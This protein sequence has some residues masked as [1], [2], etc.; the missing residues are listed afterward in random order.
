ML[1]TMVGALLLAR[2]VND[3]VLSAEILAAA[4]ASV[5]DRAGED[6]PGPV[7]ARRPAVRASAKGRRHGTA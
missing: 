6:P 7:R 4:S 2:A 5:P 3:E 1:S